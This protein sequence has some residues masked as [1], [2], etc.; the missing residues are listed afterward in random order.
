MEMEMEMGESPRWPFRV[1]VSYQRSCLGGY[2]SEQRRVLFGK[3]LRVDSRTWRS[4]HCGGRQRGGPAMMD[5]GLIARQSRVYIVYKHGTEQKNG[6]R[7]RAR[8]CAGHV[9]LQDF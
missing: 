1:R 9:Y 3:E 4:P 7:P 6:T 8:S 2:R 5:S